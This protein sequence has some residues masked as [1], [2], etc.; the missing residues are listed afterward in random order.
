MLPTKYNKDNPRVRV[1]KDQTGRIV[2]YQ[3]PDFNNRFITRDEAIIRMKFNVETSEIIDSFGRSVGEGVFAYP[4]RGRT[5]T[6]VEREARYIPL[7]EHPLRFR[8]ASNQ[9]IVERV[10]VIGKDGKLYSFETSYGLGVKFSEHKYGGRYRQK[11]S[12]AL[13][14]PENERLPTSDLQR[15]VIN[16][17]YLVKTINVKF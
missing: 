1:V 8:P 4:L 6:F 9:E 7:T 10:T 17:E 3:D 16:V 2:G 5:V 12:D 14:L 11:I 13:E 15:A